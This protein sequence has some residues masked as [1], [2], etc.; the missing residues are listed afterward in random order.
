MFTYDF[1]HGPELL[2]AVA[3]AVAV[4]VAQVAVATNFSAVTDW[5]SWAI[6]LVAAAARAAFA[7]AAKYTGI[8]AGSTVVVPQ[9]G[10]GQPAPPAPPLAP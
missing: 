7:A 5:K 6:A 3:V 10:V 9:Q 1:K 4:V 2:W 8:A